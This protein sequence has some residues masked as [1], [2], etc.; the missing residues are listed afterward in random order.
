MKLMK[1]LLLLAVFTLG[2]STVNAQTKVAHINSEELVSSMP[3]YKALQSKLEKLGKTYQDEATS[4][5]NS[6]KAKF[7]KFDQEAASQ[8]QETNAL[9]QKEVE[10]DAKK[11]EQFKMEAMNDIQAQEQAGMAP[12]LEKAQKAVEDVASE[13]GFD[14]VLNV[15]TLV[16]AKGKDILPDV[17]TK[18]G[19]Q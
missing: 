19:I 2:F 14:Y 12:I 13:Q 1:T 10:L 8:T 4:L 11:L 7:Q 17:K 16:V 9:R 5:E 6:L 15:A 18:L 3:E